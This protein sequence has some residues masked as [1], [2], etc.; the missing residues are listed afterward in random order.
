VFTGMIFLT[1][2][3]LHVVANGG[4]YYFNTAHKVHI[5]DDDNVVLTVEFVLLKC[6]LG[7]KQMSRWYLF[8]CVM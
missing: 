6:I 5:G 1:F 7:V 8:H 2:L 4:Y 3:Y